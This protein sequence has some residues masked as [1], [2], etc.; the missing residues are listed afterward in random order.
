MWKQMFTEIPSQYFGLSYDPSHLYLQRM[1]YLKPLR[2][3]KDKIFHI[4][5]KDIKLFSDKIDE[6]GIFTYP[7]RYMQPKIP[8][9][10]G[11]DW[12]KFIKVLKETSYQGYAC[13]EIE[14]K[15][16]EDSFTSVKQAIKNSYDNIVKFI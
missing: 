4:H 7:L 11:I 6:Y 9:E 5:F 3:F 8:G 10:G 16:Y 13:I 12:E 14:D 2:E 15:D 1:D